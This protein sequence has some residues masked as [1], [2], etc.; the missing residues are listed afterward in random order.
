MVTTPLLSTPLV[1]CT[2][3]VPRPNTDI[4]PVEEEPR[5][6]VCLLVV[7]STPAPVRYVALSPELAEM[8]AVG[9]PLLTFMKANLEEE[10]DTPP[11]VRSVVRFP[12]ERTP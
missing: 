10:V 11:R 1:E 9:V 6:R 12:G 5:V 7:P 8:E 2:T 4:S 3:P